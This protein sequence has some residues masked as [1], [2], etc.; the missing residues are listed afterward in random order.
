MVD[1]SQKRSNFQDRNGTS[2][3]LIDTTSCV[4]M[5]DVTIGAEELANISSYQML[6]TDKNSKSYKP[7]T[8]LKKVCHYIWPSSS[9]PSMVQAWVGHYVTPL[10]C[11]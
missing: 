5:C 3:Q 11:R 10:K 7:Q 6:P 4:K 9:H 8:K 1:Q 2:T